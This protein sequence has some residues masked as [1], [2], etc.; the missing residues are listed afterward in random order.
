MSRR[1]KQE[2][3]KR[4]YEA[5]FGKPPP[6]PPEPE[7]KATQ[8]LYVVLAIL[9]A[10][11]GAALVI[12]GKSCKKERDFAHG[13]GSSAGSV[14][15]GGHVVIIDRVTS[16]ER[17]QNDRDNVH[18]ST[19]VMV[20]DAATGSELARVLVPELVGCRKTAS[21][22][23]AWCDVGGRLELYELPQVARVLSVN[24]AI[25]TSGFGAAVAKQWDVSKDGIAFQLL[26]DGRGVKI[27]PV[28][29]KLE[30]LDTLPSE[31]QP[32]A[33]GRRHP[34]SLPASTTTCDPRSLRGGGM[35]TKISDSKNRWFVPKPGGRTVVVKGKV[36]SPELI[37][38]EVISDT[39]AMVLHAT[40][41]DP[42]NTLFQVSR[43]REDGSLAWTT[44]L[45]ANCENAALLGGTYVVTTSTPRERALGIDIETGAVRWR[46]GEP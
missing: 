7:S 23:R 30:R 10:A 11:G 32:D 6:P 37:D 3:A 9:V 25:K 28:T 33:T 2:K 17:R 36:R 40:S 43:L 12:W 46:S 18:T 26:A 31:L 20:F 21:P 1:A 42:E 24:D 44:R 22:T 27:D 4:E 29:A 34:A 41:A 8:A 19:R 39:P 5:N 45:G 38:P 13:D 16:T 14:V 15:T 35:M